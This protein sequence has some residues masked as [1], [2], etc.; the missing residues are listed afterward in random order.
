MYVPDENLRLP[1]SLEHTLTI[2]QR[3]VMGKNLYPTI[4]DK[5]AHLGYSII[6]GHPFIDG[7]KRTGMYVTLFTLN[8]NDYRTS[9]RKITNEEVVEMSLAVESGGKSEE[10]FVYWL[11][12]KVVSEPD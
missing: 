1:G 4:Y 12:E 8:V 5:A 7:N 9:V 11:R 3:K 6:V 2:I 10:D